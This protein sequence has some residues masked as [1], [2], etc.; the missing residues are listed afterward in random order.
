MLP[1]WHPVYHNP[2]QPS[3]FSETKIRH[4]NFSLNTQS[5]SASTESVADNAPFA[6]R[7]SEKYASSQLGSNHDQQSLP[8]SGQIRIHYARELKRDVN[9][10]RQ[11]DFSSLLILAREF[12]PSDLG[13]NLEVRRDFWRGT[14][15]EDVVVSEKFKNISQKTWV[16]A[17]KEVQKNGKQPER[18]IKPVIKIQIYG[19][20]K[21]KHFSNS[22]KACQ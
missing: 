12:D 22:P 1:I 16:Q 2:S 13:S 4:T 19:A 14:K 15:Q 10:S 11:K 7:Q 5:I 21:S 8:R 6:N 20:T 9:D 18:V 17:I 3:N